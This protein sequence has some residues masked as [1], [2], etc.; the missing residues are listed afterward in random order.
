MIDVKGKPINSE[1]VVTIISLRIFGELADDAFDGMG[2]LLEPKIYYAV[3]KTIK[4][5]RRHHM[6]AYQLQIKQVVNYP[7]C[8][9]CR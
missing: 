8:H 9:I 4:Q 2:I 6:S 7:R 5:Q 1:E 3:R